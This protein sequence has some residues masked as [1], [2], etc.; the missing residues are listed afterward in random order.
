[1]FSKEY[2]RHYK[3][4]IL[5]SLPVAVSQLGHIL[6]GVADT[7][8]AGRLGSL[9]LASATIATSIFIPVLMFGIGI[10]YGATSLIAKADG[11]G[12]KEEVRS[13]FKHSLIL[14]LI[15]SVVL[16]IALYNCSFVLRLLDQ[17]ATV[18]E[19]AVP[20]A[21]WLAWSILP[22]MLFQTFKQFA[23]GL[24]YTKQAMMISIGSNI[25]NVF[26][27]YVLTD[28]WM[29]IPPMGLNGI[30][31]ATLIARI[32]MAA[33]IILLIVS[34]KTFIGYIKNQ[35]L[36]RFN[37]RKVKE[38]LW[39]SLPIGS[40]MVLE[41]GAFGF[42][43]IM[44]GWLGEGEIAIAAHQ[45]A[46]N[47]AAVTY[48]AATGISASATVR[49]GNEFGRK[50]YKQLQKAGYSAFILVLGYMTITA[51]LFVML[52]FYLPTLYINETAVIQ[53]ASSLLL[54]AAFFQLSDGVQVVGFGAL[55]GIGDVIMPTIAVLV[56]YYVIGLPLG[57]WLAFRSNI[58]IEGV[59]YG[60]SFGLVFVSIFLF[61]RFR[62]KSEKLI[63]NDETISSFKDAAHP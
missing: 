2:I 21:E 29:G 28:G 10:S 23:E 30:A 52:R 18:V 50:D 40:Q 11:A 60:L 37:P 33:A 57:Y 48:M 1:M 27:I 3:E 31:I 36:L 32:V 58:G 19:A 45:I 61:F 46:L 13:I 8:M 20:F 63:R 54:I 24:S 22:L 34:D 9:P 51:F 17:P 41:S 4:H 6:V 39:I 26:L 35:N 38:L 42:A 16:F 55:R 62:S 7:I 47:M 44:V 14:N 25:L 12:D 59:W 43:A 49:V 5:L 53:M 56:A 15:L